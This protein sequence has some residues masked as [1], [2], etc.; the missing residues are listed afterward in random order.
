MIREVDLVSY[1]PPFMR[2][3][4]EPVAALEAENPEFA[5][6]WKAA[7]RALKNGFI[8]TADEYGIGR[9]EKII[10]LFPADT[11]SLEVRRVRV[12]SRWSNFIPYTNRILAEK[13]A[14]VL[15]GED[16]FSINS[17][18]GNAYGIELVVYSADESL[19]DE[20]LHLLTVMVPSNMV[21][22]L[23]Y[24]PVTRRTA[25]YFGTTVEQADILEIRQR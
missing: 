2:T 18:F 15:G 3:Y 10:G 8:G 14:G 5:L 16:R 11:D 25:V 24:E 12:Q 21:T 23:V 20:L 17:D 7:D 1:L 9:F 22:E 13:I 19:V 4:R 6:V